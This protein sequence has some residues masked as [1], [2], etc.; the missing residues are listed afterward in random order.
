M[1]Q[2]TGPRIHA[3][4]SK[5]KSR[6]KYLLLPNVLFEELGFTYLGPVSGHDIQS[7]TE[8][9]NLAKKVP[10][11]VLLHVLTVKG[12]GYGPAEK[13]PSRFH[14][15]GKFDPDTGRSPGTGPR[16][17]FAAP[18]RG[19]FGRKPSVKMMSILL[20]QASYRP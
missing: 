15:I 14:G 2:K 12:K 13:E 7:L 10:N 9:L 20:P 16:A 18:H 6:I 4:L 5:V 8:A 19:A 11:P 1:Q 3:W 17:A